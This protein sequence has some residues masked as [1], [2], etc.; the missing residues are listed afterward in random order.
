MLQV[1]SGPGW[2]VRRSG[3][4]EHGCVVSGAG[5]RRRVLRAVR[6]LAALA[7]ALAVAAWLAPVAPV[8]A[9]EAEPFPTRMLLEMVDPLLCTVPPAEFADADVFAIL[10][11]EDPDEA[12]PIGGTLTAD[13]TWRVGGAGYYNTSPSHGMVIGADLALYD[14]A[15]S[16]LFLCLALLPHEDTRIVAGP[17]RLVG[18]DA[19]TV[20]DDT[21]MAIGLMGEREGDRF[22]A[23]SELITERGRMVLKQAPTDTLDGYLV[24]SG[25]LEPLPGQPGSVE[26]V[27]LELDLK[28]LE[29]LSE[30]QVVNWDDGDVGDAM[31]EVEAPAAAVAEPAA[32]AADLD[33]IIA[34]FLADISVTLTPVLTAADSA[35]IAHTLYAYEYTTFASQG[36]RGGWY[37]TGSKFLYRSGD[38]LIAYDENPSTDVERIAFFDALID[39][40]FVLD[41]TSA[42]D[43]RALLFTLA[44]EHFFS[45]VPVD[46]IVHSQPGEWA[47]LAGT[48]F[49]SYKAFVVSTDASGRVTGVGYKLAYAPR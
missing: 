10:R 3:M 39:P 38:A 33:E 17:A 47:F 45:S 41:A 25:R 6:S 28:A 19:E 29:R 9:D 31:A 5:R 37:S 21:F 43:F 44:G 42:T 49:D 15:E 8:Y 16:L 27:T 30:M 13:Q 24:L 22:V 32:D 4:S 7:G 23:R 48:F 1:V 11:S 40:D 35:I 20:T 12:P 36:D 2:M 26:A 46:P 14:E 34:L 18:P